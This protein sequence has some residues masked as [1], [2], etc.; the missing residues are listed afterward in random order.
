MPIEHRNGEK[1]AREVL[2]S[3]VLRFGI[4]RQILTDKGSN[5]P[6][7]LFKEAYKLLRIKKS[8]CSAFHLE[9]N[10]GL[11]RSHATPLELVYGLKSGV[12]SAL[13]ETPSI[14]YS[15]DN[16]VMKIKGRL[17]TA[18]EIASQ[19]LVSHKEAKSTVIRTR[20]K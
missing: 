9:S 7:N 13:R 3:I 5:F 1:V 17:Q 2:L 15:Y 20:N 4:P 10:G 16:F 6:S 12:P 11:E 18:H 19:K 8:Q 14:S